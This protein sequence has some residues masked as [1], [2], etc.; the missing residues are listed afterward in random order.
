MSPVFLNWFFMA[1]RGKSIKKYWDMIPSNTDILITHCP[2]YGILDWIPFCYDNHNVGCEELLKVV[3][4]IKPKVH[5]FGHIH[6][7]YGTYIGN[8]TLFVNVSVMNEEYQVVN[9]PKEIDIF[10]VG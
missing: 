10:S 5:I 8:E 2:P 7:S 6:G 9:K 3:C 4:K 1:Q